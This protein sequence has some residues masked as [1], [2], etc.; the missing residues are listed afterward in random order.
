MCKEGKD[1][2]KHLKN[3]QQN[4]RAKEKQAAFSSDYDDLLAVCSVDGNKNL[5]V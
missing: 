4:W 2:E 1:V 3:I 5:A